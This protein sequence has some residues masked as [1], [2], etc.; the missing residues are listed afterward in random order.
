MTKD[1]KDATDLKN[2]IDKNKS[3][4]AAQ[5]NNYSP[6]EGRGITVRHGMTPKKTETPAAEDNKK[7]IDKL[8]AN[9]N[10]KNDS[11]NQPITNNITN[12]NINNNINNNTSNATNNATNNSNTNNSLPTID[13]STTT[14][15][16]A[17]ATDFMKD[18][19]QNKANNEGSNNPKQ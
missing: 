8:Q 12:N 9:L 14:K 15:Y 2:M 4:Y 6:A 1:A 18:S 19:W 13:N 5:A 16:N 10:P 3:R 11:N 17:Q 7:N